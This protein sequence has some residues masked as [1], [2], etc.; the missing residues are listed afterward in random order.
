MKSDLEQLIDE[1][2]EKRLAIM[3]QEDYQF[4]KQA[5]KW[6]YILI[7]ASIV[8]CFALIWWGVGS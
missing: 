3:E 1:E 6:D 4:P 8:V 7:M 5:T 2:T